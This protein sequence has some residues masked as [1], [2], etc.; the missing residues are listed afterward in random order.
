MVVSLARAV[1]IIPIIMSSSSAL[2]DMLLDADRPSEGYSQPLPVVD[3]LDGRSAV[4]ASLD[5]TRTVLLFTTIVEFNCPVCEADLV[6][7]DEDT[8]R[9][10]RFLATACAG[11]FT[12]FSLDLQ[13][14]DTGEE[15]SSGAKNEQNE[16]NNFSEP[17]STNESNRNNLLNKTTPGGPTKGTA[18]DKISA[19]WF[20]QPPPHYYKVTQR[21]GDFF[22]LVPFT[23]IE[24]QQM[25]PAVA[26]QDEESDWSGEIRWSDLESDLESESGS[27]SDLRTPRGGGER[28]G[29]TSSSG[30]GSKESGGPSSGGGGTE[31]YTSASILHL[32]IRPHT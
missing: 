19:R 1:L 2:P 25:V 13:D 28:S 22:R 7:Q 6:V 12:Q 9:T 4:D 16:K 8:K 20:L 18:S 24:K 5:S 27:R 11:C 31:F 32:P 26:E 30:P 15:Q 21:G 17:S 10:P 14:D 3:H 29:T 23:T